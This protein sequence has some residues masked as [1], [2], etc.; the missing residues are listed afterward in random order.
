MSK[1]TNRTKNFRITS[2]TLEKPW[3]GSLEELVENNPDL[4]VFSIRHLEHMAPGEV[5][6]PPYGPEDFK[7]RRLS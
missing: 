1:K 5:V 2:P 6:S 3:E 4:T 7:I